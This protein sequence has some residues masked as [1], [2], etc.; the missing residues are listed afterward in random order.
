MIPSE[1]HACIEAHVKIAVAPQLCCS[2][3]LSESC[4]PRLLELVRT[5]KEPGIRTY[6]EAAAVLSLFEFIWPQP[7]CIL[8]TTSQ[9]I[10][11][12]I[13]L[14]VL[15]LQFLDSSTSFFDTTMY[16]AIQK[17]FLKLKGSCPMYSINT[18]ICIIQI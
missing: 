10:K 8:F 1:K 17:R 11:I 15:Y 5:W 4:R 6:T 13:H 16:D 7:K 14:S 2:L 12:S 18:K 9:R 3:I